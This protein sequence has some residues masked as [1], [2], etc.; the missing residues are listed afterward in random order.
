VL[1]NYAQYYTLK[2][3]EELALFFKMAEQFSSPEIGRI[4]IEKIKPC[5]DS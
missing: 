3:R 2:K 4:L 5:Q 1:V